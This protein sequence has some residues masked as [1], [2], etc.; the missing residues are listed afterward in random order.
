MRKKIAI[1]GAGGL[2]REVLTLISALSE[3]NATGYYDDNLSKGTIIKNLPVL[4]SVQDL[5]D[6]EENYNV[7][8]AIGDVNAKQRVIEKL[9]HRNQIHYPVLIHPHAILQ[10]HLSIAM[11][12][13][14]VIAAG[15]ILTADIK[16]GNHVLI[17]LNCTVGHGSIIGNYCSVMPGVNIAGNVV[18]GNQVLIGS[19]SNLLPGISVGD[20]A[21]IGAGAVVT[22]SVL[23]D[24]TVVGIPA[25]ELKQSK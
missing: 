7:V 4:G 16:I 12:A 11:G 13:G 19:G 9:K 23:S 2:G 6:L 15:S 25:R 3:W 5:A 17:N 20:H 21:R 14:T 18:I 1:I 8:I 10:E 24:K 22:K